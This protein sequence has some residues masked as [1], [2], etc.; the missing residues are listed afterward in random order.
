MCKAFSLSSVWLYFSFIPCC[1]NR[2]IC[3]RFT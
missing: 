1:L 3:C 2:C